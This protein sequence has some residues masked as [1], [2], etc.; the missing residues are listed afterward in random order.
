[1]KKMV[2]AALAAV[3]VCFSSSLFAAEPESFLKGT[4]FGLFEDE[5][6]DNLAWGVEDADGLVLGGVNDGI[7]LGIGAFIGD[8]WW[9]IYDFA[10]INT[11]ITSTQ[12]VSNDS[13]AKDGINTD[14]V[15]VDKQKTK[16][17]NTN[18]IQNNLYLSFS[19]D[20]W[21]IQSYWLFS[22]YATGAIGKQSEESET[23]T[24]GIKWN[25]DDKQSR[26]TGTNTFG[27]NFKGI[28]A[29]DLNDAGLYFQLNNFQVSWWNNSRK[30]EY[31][32]SWK[33]NGVS[34]SETQTN[35][36]DYDSYSYKLNNNTITPS[37]E[38]EMGFDL[39]E[40]GALS[41]KFV[42]KENFDITFGGGKNTTVTTD[43]IED[44][45]SK[46]VTKTTRTVKSGSSNYRLQFNNFLTPELVFDFDVGERVKVKGAAGATIW[47]RNTPGA[48]NGV[49]TTITNSETSYKVT[50]LKDSYY[51]K[52]VDE[53]NNTTVTNKFATSVH[54]ST[55]LAVVYEVKPE[56]FNLNFG[57]SWNA[58]ELKWET[59]TVK[60]ITSKDT[61]YRTETDTAGQKTVTSDTVTYTR[62]DTAADQAANAV[63]ESKTTVYTASFTGTP[64]FS[65]GANWFLNDK[66][67]LDMA[68]TSAVAFNDFRIMKDGFSGSNNG[69]LDSTF[70]IQLS[71]KF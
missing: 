27:A 6:V 40:F 19:G 57:F 41:T 38:A 46:T 30:R 64:E 7:D 28:G 44:N 34:Y 35:D 43:V 29:T 15:D 24:T 23:N 31:K 9:S 13:V 4:T 8:L 10:N 11:N 1:M 26:Y 53:G 60:N 42:L 59:T 5:V 37:F 14:Y 70:K 3:L 55:T 58:G 62:R 32:R 20:D 71:V 56:K 36:E 21:G 50:H 22:N 16:T 25:K 17:N 52:S 12:N 69:L 18:N 33:Q 54:P 2:K 63:A 48:K 49:T 61:Y 39:P 65:I 68:Y 47:V 51:V 45:N 67:Q 66:V